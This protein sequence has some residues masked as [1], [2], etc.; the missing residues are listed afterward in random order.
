MD[1]ALSEEVRAAR[2]AGRPLVTLE[3]SVLAQ[4]LPFPDNLASQHACEAAVRRAGA[5]PALVAVVRGQLRCGLSDSE[6]ESLAKGEGHPRKV[7]GRDLAPALA[8]SRCPAVA[9][10]PTA[11]SWREWHGLSSPS[12][13]GG[14]RDGP[15]VRRSR[16]GKP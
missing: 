1:V 6:V 16:P 13:G 8:G 3:S 9:D 4:G 11:R 2:T 12:L 7:G 15:V 5:V 10:R 14:L